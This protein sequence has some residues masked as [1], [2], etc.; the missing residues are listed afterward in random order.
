MLSFYDAWEEAENEEF[1][2]A[3]DAAEA[4]FSQP[5]GHDAPSRVVNDNPNDIEVDMFDDQVEW[6]NEQRLTVE[7]MQPGSPEY[8]PFRVK[9]EPDDDA[10]MDDSH[11]H[12]IPAE[13][14]EQIHAATLDALLAQELEERL[15]TDALQSKAMPMAASG[16][17]MP[18]VAP[19]PPPPKFSSSRVVPPP[20]RQPPPVTHAADDVVN[21]APAAKRKAGTENEGHLYVS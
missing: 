1:Y 7:V 13:M 19:L 15:A 11:D 12:P 10:G 3:W 6:E 16:P 17:P 20:Q 9:P 21:F 2:G 18:P 5:R 14:L 8:D 4:A